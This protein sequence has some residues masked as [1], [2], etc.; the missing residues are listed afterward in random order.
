MSDPIDRLDEFGSSFEG[1]AM[2]KSAAEI[3]RRGDQIRRRRHAVVGG[4]AAAAVAAVAVPVFAVVGSPGSDAPSPAESPTA[5]DT[6]VVTPAGRITRAN[7][8]VA[9]DIAGND[10]VGGQTVGIVRTARG[11]GQATVNPCQESSLAGMGASLVIQRDFGF[12]AA[13]GGDGDGDHY[14]NQT[15]AQFESADAARAAA[16]EI[17][18]WFADCVPAGAEVV[19]DEQRRDLDVPGAEVSATRM[20][21]GPAEAVPG[22]QYDVEGRDDLMWHLETGTVVIGDRLAMVTDLDLDSDLDA[23]SDAD[24]WALEG[25]LPAAAQRLVVGDAADE[26]PGG[27]SGTG[28]DGRPDLDAPAGTTRVP[29]DFPLDVH[30]DEGAEQAVQVSGP[31]PLENGV[32]R[33][34]LCGEA[35]AVLSRLDGERLGYGEVYEGE[36]YHGRAVRAY[37][38]VQAAVDEVDRLRAQLA[39]CEQDTP[40][41]STE[42]RVWHTFD[43]A[44]G[45]DDV[46]FGYTLEGQ[47]AGGLYTVVR[48]GNAVLSL[49]T[50]GEYTLPSLRSAVPGHAALVGAIA[51]EMCVFTADG[52]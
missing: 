13:E 16:A 17:D 36:A 38:T 50:A 6:S 49:S 27:A 42:T 3:R 47:A 4:A 1:G 43:P 41:E 31:D 28:T 12:S 18:D 24:L 20:R 5:T 11:D 30:L 25:I 19:E 22:S 45:W 7:L 10:G 29:E 33:T 51:P 8:L 35:A 26:D 52:C 44:T 39:A 23:G 21:Y 14:L 46:T 40:Y 32:F 37:P 34:D 15:I 2:P 9:P 48:V